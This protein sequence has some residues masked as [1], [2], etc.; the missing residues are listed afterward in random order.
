MDK[1]RVDGDMDTWIHMEDWKKEGYDGVFI[2]Q[3][4]CWNDK[5]SR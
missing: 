4:Y 1:W 2:S 3:K 5:L